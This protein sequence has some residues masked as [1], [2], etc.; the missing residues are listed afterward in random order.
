MNF[1]T[2]KSAFA[3][4]ALAISFMAVEAHALAIQGLSANQ[5]SADTT[6]IKV[7]FDGQPVTPVAYQQAGGKQLTLDFNQVSSGGLPRSMPIN[8]GVVNEVT[9]LNNGSMT[10]LMI[11]LKDS[12]SYTSTVQG[13]QLLINIKQGGSSTTQSVANEPA[14]AVVATPVQ[15]EAQPM[16]VKVNPLL[17]PTSGSLASSY[18]G[19]S[20]VDYSGNANGGNVTVNL[21]NESIPVDVQRQGNKLVVRTTGTTIPRHLLKRINGSGLVADIDA[22]NQGQNGVITVNMT[23]DFEYQAYQSG[24]T[25]NISVLPPKMLREPTIEEKVYTG[26][27]LSMEFQDVSVRTVL[28]VLGQFTEN[29]IVAADN[30]QG[31]ITLRLINVPW[32]QALDI[33]LKSKNLGQRKNGNVILVA[34]AEELAAREIK[35]LEDAKKVDELEPIR[36]EHIRL[37]YAKAEDIHGLLD[38]VGSSSGSNNNRN[39]LLSPRGNAT[40]D[41]R[42]NTIIINDTA[43]S[44]ANVRQLIETIDIPVK[45]VMI[46]AR[47]VN[48]SDSFSKQLGV[49]WGFNRTGN[50]FDIRGMKGLSS[51]NTE[52]RFGNFAVDLGV[53]ATSGISL[54]LLNIDNY[55]LGLELSAMQADNKGEIIS[56]PKVLTSDKQP[57]R[58][59]S[60]VDIPYQEASASGATTVSFKEAALVL[61]AT[62]NITP[63]GKIGLDLEITNSADSG[64]R[65]LGVPILNTDEIKTNV[66]LEDGQTVVL[67]GVF[68]NTIGNNQ[69]KVPFLGDLPGVGRLFRNNVRLNNKEELLIFVTPRIVNDGVS[70]Y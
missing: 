32:D 4:S 3:Y 27:P 17:A 5:I 63:E 44:I 8:R 29:N 36:Q 55:A 65:V 25:L 26:E 64:N 69:S 56:S 50:K 35:E 62:P 2:K 1:L 54:G 10:R 43:R 57:A 30:V 22:K 46:E 52:S 60:G 33:I 14:P 49:R 11:N 7:A 38:R 18:D 47:I 45:Q 31:N 9:A 13:N 19:V 20:T 28:D 66:I 70:R 21:T 24:A 59:S 16:T 51:S 40:F 15:P 42:T 39:S 61:S 34:P 23:G 67:G 37:N 12:A 6:Q 41:G 48:A 58:I 68:K 53:A